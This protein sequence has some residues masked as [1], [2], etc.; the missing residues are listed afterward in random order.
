MSY[1]EIKR[2]LNSNSKERR[3]AI[4]LALFCAPLIRGIAIANVLRVNLSEFYEIGKMLEGTG[5]SYEFLAVSK[6]RAVLFLYRKQEL[7]RYLSNKKIQTFLH[8]YGYYSD[9]LFEM[10][11]HLAD[12]ICNCNN[13]KMGFPH[14]IGVFLGYPLADVVEFIENAGQNCICVGYWKV[15]QDVENAKATFKR[16]DEERENVV[17]EVI[18]G[19]TICEI[20]K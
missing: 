9:T 16:F 15:Y 3:V 13:G 10:I 1:H 4:T 2:L 8:S 12:R 5:I 14:E 19:K 11:N 20:A 17:R 7:I 6:N 18:R